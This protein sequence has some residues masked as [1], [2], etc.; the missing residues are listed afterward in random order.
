MKRRALLIT[1]LVGL[2]VWTGMDR[3]NAMEQAKSVEFGSPASPPSRMDADGAIIEDWGRLVF[4][5]SG[6]GIPASGPVS[7][8]A[9][10]IESVVPAAVA[11]AKRGPLEVTTAAFRSP[12][13]PAG[14]DVVTLQIKNTTGAP[15]NARLGLPL[16]DGSRVGRRTVMWGGRV[17]LALPMPIDVDAK[18]REWGSDDDSMP[19][20]GW[21]KPDVECDPSFRSIRAGMN[22]VPIVYK[23]SVPPASLH[24]VVL[25]ICESH[26]ESSG[27]RPVVLKVEGA[28]AMTVDPLARWGRHKPGALLFS[29]KDENG[30]G[31]LVISALPA[32]GA[33]DAN[34]I[35]N[36]IWLFPAGTNP[37]IEQVILGRMNAVATRMVDV[38]GEKDQSLYLPGKAEY[39]L[40]ITANGTTELTFFV[41]AAG[42]SA[43]MPGK[44]GWTLETLRKAA[45]EVNRDWKEK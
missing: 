18:K 16:P 36:A 29:G 2:L 1:G 31:T 5:L 34:P 30:D 21:G 33:P 38:G 8:Q 6:E 14:T 37:N 24:D 7:V 15:V 9:T 39:A 23:F 3:L 42:G 12:T 44:S 27:T 11:R 17:I 19:M 45:I 43:P 26:W 4:T 22:G 40:S 41:G 13:Y 28:P 32:P 20:P 25:G 35:L 10:K